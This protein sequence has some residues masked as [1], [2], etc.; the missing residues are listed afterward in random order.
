MKILIVEDERKLALLLKQGLSE[1]GY[2]VTLAA[3]C[4]AARDALCETSF[5]AIVLDLGL[6]DGD[7]LELLRQCRRS[8]FNEPV[9]ILSSHD[10]VQDGLM[11]PEYDAGVYLPY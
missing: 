9:I 7:G 5:D 2:G 10:S 1:A 3:A 4:A 6:P 8:G 11:G